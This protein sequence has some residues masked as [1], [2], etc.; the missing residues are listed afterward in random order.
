MNVKDIVRPLQAARRA[1]RMRQGKVGA[2]S[3][4]LR[5]GS[6]PQGPNTERARADLFVHERS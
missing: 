6:V 5:L 2:N 3:P 4:D 1:A